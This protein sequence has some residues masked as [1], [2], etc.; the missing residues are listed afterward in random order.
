MST[1]TGETIRTFR[2]SLLASNPI[3]ATCLRISEETQ[4]INGVEY[5]LTY[6]KLNGT[7]LMIMGK[8]APAIGLDEYHYINNGEHITDVTVKSLY[9]NQIELNKFIVQYNTI[10]EKVKSGEMQTNITGDMIAQT[11]SGGLPQFT[12]ARKQSEIPAKEE[13]IIKLNRQ[14]VED[15]YLDIQ[16]YILHNN[17]DQLRSSIVEFFEGMCGI[18][19]R[20]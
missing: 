10:V 15:T 1:V 7:D 17:Q 19:G 4:N 9:D 20:K 14:D 5:I 18:K 16:Y 13:K 3:A 2:D 8:S 6:L 12:P 11:M